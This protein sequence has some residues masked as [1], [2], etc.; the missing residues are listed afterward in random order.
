MDDRSLMAEGFNPS[1]EA[2]VRD[3]DATLDTGLTQPRRALATGAVLTS[4]AAVVMDAGISNAALPTMSVQLGIAASDAVLV[5]TAY[6][7]AV[8]MA[9]LPCAALAERFGY[10]RIFSAGVLL[11]TSASAVSALAPSLDTLIPSRFVQGLGG[12]AILALG[13]ALLRF[14]V[15]DRRLGAA[16]SWNALTVAVSSAAGPAIGAFLL[17]RADWHWIYVLNLPLGAA[18]LLAVRALPADS[19]RGGPL[20]ILSMALSGAAFA[21]S[22]AAVELAAAPIWA[23]IAVAAAATAAVAL[24]RRETPKSN[25]FLPIDLLRAPSF[26]R[27]LAASILCFTGQ[28]AGL[29]ALPFFL[30]YALGQSAATAAL[31][32]STWP[33]GVALTASIAGRLADRISGAWLCAAG[34]TLLAIGL[35]AIALLPWRGTPH[36]V[37]V[38]TALGGAGFGLFQVANNRNMFLAAPRARSGAAGALQGTARVSGQTAGALLVATLFAV[39]PMDD[40]PELAMCFGAIMTSL[41][42][43]LSLA[44][45]RR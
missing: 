44:R 34:G 17:S 29:I 16:I 38:F 31:Y 10:R 23:A 18:V 4:M 3:A 15:S 45:V 40:A 22:I 5:V 21:L 30:Q 14:S 25:P 19:A 28:T 7:A 39:A 11:F 24:V 20:D 26:A 27:S 8:V 32:M 12:A 42:G 35:L 41:A 43:A 2:A 33:A 9:L 1:S 37:V 36:V 13:V 6:Q